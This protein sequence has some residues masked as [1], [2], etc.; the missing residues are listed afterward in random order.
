VVVAILLLVA[1]FFALQRTK[2]G[3][4]LRAVAE[5]R[6]MAAALGVPVVKVYFIALAVSSGLA[7]LAG[8]LIVPNTSLYP[9]VGGDIILNAFI[10]VVAGG[11]GNLKGA[12]LIALLLG[13][14]QALGSIVIPPVQVELV[15]FA[16]VILVMISRTYRATALVRL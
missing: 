3:I 6:P 16:L 2:Y 4:W 13:E 9:T 15:L 12:A 11:L 5:N 10:I 14:I 7:G 1:G 8:A